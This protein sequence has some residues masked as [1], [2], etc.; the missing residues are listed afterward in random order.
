MNF[1]FAFEIQSNPGI[2]KTPLLVSNFPPVLQSSTKTNVQTTQNK[3]LTNGINDTSKPGINSIF[4]P[5]P[6]LFSTI[7]AKKHPGI[8]TR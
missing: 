5:L 1:L 4:A 3:P 8:E 6:I 2:I 7:I